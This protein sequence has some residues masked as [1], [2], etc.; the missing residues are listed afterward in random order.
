M[1]LSWIKKKTTKLI[2]NYIKLNLT[3]IIAEFLL[4]KLD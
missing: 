2:L 1:K 3:F 4:K